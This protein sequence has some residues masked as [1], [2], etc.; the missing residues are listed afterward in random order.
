M[1]R[2]RKNEARAWAREHMTGCDCVIIPSYT[3]DL[4][5]MNER[6]VRH[7]VRRCIELGFEG[8][9]IVSEVA[10]TL[11]EYRS[12]TEW[13]ADEAKGR[14]RIVHHASFNTLE[15]N[16][17]AVRL[18]E[19][20]GADYVL[21][22]YPAN[23]Y[24][25]TSQEVYDYTKAF[26]DGTKLG[27]MLFQVPLWNFGRLHPSDLEPAL[28]RRLL[29]DVPNIIAIKAEGGM[30]LKGGLTDAYRLFRDQVI[31]SCPIEA[32]VIPL[33]S[34]MEFQYSGTSNTHF[35]GNSVPRM[36][37]LA[38]EKKFDEAMEIYWRIQPARAANGLANGGT[39]FTG[40]LNRMVWNY[41]G[42]LQGMNG[43]PLRQPTNKIN[44]R[45]MA[46]LRRG[47]AEAKLD[48]TRDPN[49]AYFVGRNP[50][51]K[52]VAQAHRAAE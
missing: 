23:F 51:P 44:D 19:A 45:Q 13:A 48:P 6:G 10:L 29:Q 46:M 3:S 7:D 30:P 35:Y 8:A 18:T 17:E 27:V 22:S 40:F 39:P 9:L 31:I 12:V 47:L 25:T 28:L 14:L 1:A 33:M 26:C 2:Y 11:D 43:G 16:I 4:R 34:V 49:T 52:P 24:P 15:E 50:M 42:W 38:R 21:L 37:Q 36:F 5:G 20:A 41:Q 32:D